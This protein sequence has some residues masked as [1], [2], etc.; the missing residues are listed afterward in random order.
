MDADE[1]FSRAGLVSSWQALIIGN[2]ARTSA[3]G[4]SPI[5]SLIA[6]LLEV[7]AAIA[8]VSR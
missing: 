5:A 2:V 3:L 4:E 1:R 8:C 6:S 7:G